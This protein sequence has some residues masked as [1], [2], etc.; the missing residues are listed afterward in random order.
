VKPIPTGH[1]EP[2]LS[3]QNPLFLLTLVALIAIVGGAGAAAARR[4]KKEPPVEAPP[5][6]A[7]AQVKWE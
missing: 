7:G 5:A 2:F 1:K 4:R 6:D 3:L